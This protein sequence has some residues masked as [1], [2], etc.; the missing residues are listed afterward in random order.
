[1][2]L[3]ELHAILLD[4]TL[5]VA[6]RQWTAIGV[7]GVRS[8]PDTIVDPEALLLAT[9]EIGR[10][11]ARLFDEALD[12]VASN[13]ACVDV[14]RL[15]RLGKRATA[16]QRRL[17]SVVLGITAER[18]AAAS[19]QRLPDEEFI[20]KEVEADYGT[21]PLFR[22]QRGL[23]ATWGEPD[24]RFA[25]VG[26]LRANTQLRGLSGSPEATRPACIR[27]RA[28]ALVGPGSRA[29]VLTYL[30]THEWAHG[31]RIAER[32]A[33]GQAPV[34]DY[35]STLAD[36]GLADKRVDGRRTL[37]RASGALRAVGSPAPRYVDWIRV[38]PSLVALLDSLRPDDISEDA[39]RVRLASALSAHEEDWRAEGLEAEIGQMSGWAKHP[40]VLS[41]AVESVIERLQ[42]L[43]D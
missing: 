29:E 36:V 16:E 9:L 35:L 18:G 34:A 25:R 28:R 30:W 12:W 26:F 8:A 33:Y 3:N 17:L 37:Y 1:M 10:W 27:F 31:R 5:E 24:A 21:V 4:V 38:W 7:V 23:D 22:S 40:Q 32:S 19:L 6:W 13:A 11:D 15:R 14:A 43:V 39:A 20:A 2:S 41:D 42:G